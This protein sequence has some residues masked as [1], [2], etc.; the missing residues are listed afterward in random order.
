MTLTRE[1]ILTTEDYC[2]NLVKDGYTNEEGKPLKC[3]SCE[4]TKLDDGECVIEEHAIVEYIVRCKSCKNVTG[5][6]AYGTWEVM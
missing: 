6:W 4:S 3:I 1:E 2:R 5:H